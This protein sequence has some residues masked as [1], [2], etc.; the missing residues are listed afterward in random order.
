MVWARARHGSLSASQRT[1]IRIP[2]PQLWAKVPVQAI[3]A[4]LTAQADSVRGVSQRR[5]ADRERRLMDRLRAQGWWC[6]R[7]A[8]SH[9]CADIAALKAG[10]RPLL[11]QVKSD[12]RSAFNNFPPAERAELVATAAQT[13][14]DAW[15]VWWPPRR[16][17]EWI[18]PERWPK[19][20]KPIS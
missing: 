14:A 13:G 9:G 5:G 12:V 7:A 15:L 3:R 16:D 4:I 10:E 11:I 18:E 1:R 2:F 20:R 17:P 19:P 8:G 6:V